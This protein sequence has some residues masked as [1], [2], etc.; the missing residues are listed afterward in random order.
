MQPIP[1]AG[2]SIG[3]LRKVIP[4]SLFEFRHINTAV[5]GG[6]RRQQSA[7]QSLPQGL[8]VLLI[9]QGRGADKL[10]RFVEIGVIQNL[11]GGGQIMGAGLA[12]DSL[13]SPLRLLQFGNGLPAG[14]MCNI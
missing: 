10:G 13:A 9:P 11:L 14:H 8:T 1:G 2:G 12:G 7:G 3:D 4:A 6:D 5:V